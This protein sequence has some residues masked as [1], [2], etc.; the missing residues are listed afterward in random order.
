ML[1]K[2]V[3]TGQHCLMWRLTC[4]CKVVSRTTAC[5]ALTVAASTWH[6]F[7]GQQH[8]CQY[9]LLPSTLQS[10]GQCVCRKECAGLDSQGRPR[11]PALVAWSL[12]RYLI[13]GL[14]SCIP[15]APAGKLGSSSGLTA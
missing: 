14:L 3:E 2:V 13:F 10:A 12:Q 8:G 7:Y 4:L 9:H 11:K 15:G 1:Q 5:T 6:R